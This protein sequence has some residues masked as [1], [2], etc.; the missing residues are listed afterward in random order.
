L[1]ILSNRIIKNSLLLKY[2]GPLGH[3]L[4]AYRHTPG[5]II[6]KSHHR[7]SN[8]TAWKFWP[9]TFPILEIL[10]N[11]IIEKI[12]LFKYNGPLGLPLY[13]YRHT[14]GGT[15]EKSQYRI[16]NDTAWKFWPGTF[17]VLEILSNR[18]IEK[19]LLFKYN[20]PLESS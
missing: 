15:F 8:G 10:S 19:I 1:E 3:P 2:N 9:G 5:G 16:L 4:Y 6:E 7:F 12:L 11:R 17:P 14:P 20:G 18:I 13:A